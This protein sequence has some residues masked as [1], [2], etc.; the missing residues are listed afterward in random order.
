MES[1]RIYLSGGMSG[2]S[3]EE[4]SKWRNNM[5]N[6]IK[7]NKECEKTVYFF[8]PVDYYNFEEKQHKSEKEIMEF[9]LYN[10]RNSNL[11]VVNFN[12]V[13]SIGTA[14]ELM[15]AKEYNIPVIAFGVN[16]QDVHPWLLECCTRIC[17]NMRETVEHV[18]EF[19]LN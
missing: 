15:L 4:Q 6:E 14:M 18:V 9:D 10:L 12:N 2:L 5:M 11:V 8:N 7:Y 3:F 16:G 13:L 19:Y 17:D 1:C